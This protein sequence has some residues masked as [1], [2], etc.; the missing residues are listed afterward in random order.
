MIFNEKSESS[1]IV[2]INNCAIEKVDE[3]KLLGVIVDTK[4]KFSSHAEYII[5]KMNKKLAVLRRMKYKFN[6]DNKVMFYK[7]LIQPHLDYCAF[8]FRMCDKKYLDKL[9]SIQ[10]SSLRACTMQSSEINYVEF[11]EKYKI[12]KV[13]TRIRTNVIKVVDK[14]IKVNYPIKIREKIKTNDQMRSR[15]L[16]YQDEYKLPTY[17]SRIGQKSFMYEAINEYNKFNRFVKQNNLC[18]NVIKNCVKFYK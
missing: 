3:Y 4:F 7:S 8:I 13:E 5:K 18:N 10:N 2:K 12:V 1:L 17:I 15:S 14:I 16:R 9:Q 11:R 6:V